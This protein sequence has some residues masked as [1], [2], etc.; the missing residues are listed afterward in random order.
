MHSGGPMGHIHSSVPSGNMHIAGQH[1]HHASLHMQTGQQGGKPMGNIG[2]IS[3]VS[4]NMPMA[5]M[6]GMGRATAMMARGKLGKKGKTRNIVMNTQGASSKGKG[7]PGIPVGGSG[8]GVITSQGGKPSMGMFSQGNNAMA[9]NVSG[10]KPMGGNMIGSGQWGS[11][12]MS[13]VQNNASGNT[14]F[15]GASG[16]GQTMSTG[17]YGAASV[18]AGTPS[19]PPPPHYNTAIAQQQMMQSGGGTPHMGQ[20]SRFPNTMNTGGPHTSG[21]AMGHSG[22]QALQNMLRARGPAFM[23]SGVNNSSNVGNAASG[24][25]S[26]FVSPRQNFQGGVPQGSNVSMQGTSGGT[27]NRFGSMSGPSSTGGT[28]TGMNTRMPG[29]YNSQGVGLAQGGSSAGSQF[30]SGNYVGGAQGP[31]GSTSGPMQGMSSYMM[32]GPQPGGGYGAG[33]VGPSGQGMMSRQ[34]VMGGNMTGVQGAGGNF[35]SR[36]GQGN[37][38]QSPNVNM[39]GVIQGGGY[40]NMGS[41]PQQTGA[42]GNIGTQSNMMDRM[43]MQNPQLLAQ[44]QRGPANAQANAPNNQQMGSGFQQNRF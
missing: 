39:G 6:Q 41:M 5:H 19:Q 12:N 38:M 29:Q 35:V 10:G 25:P 18:A 43:R 23:G 1:Q 26:Q 31:P 11:G 14:P 2:N 3:G 22:K 34:N 24:N 33:G 32:R 13:S 7:I 40:R 16:A 17:S 44:L 27:G 20:A 21:A 15:G 37:Y 30:N 42:P 9:T 8:Q 4:G 28:Q 36:M